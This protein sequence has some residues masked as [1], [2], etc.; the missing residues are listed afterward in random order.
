MRDSSARNLFLGTRNT[1]FG[2][3]RSTGCGPNHSGRYSAKT[4][5]CSCVR[6]HPR[7]ATRPLRTSRSALHHRPTL[8]R[9]TGRRHVDGTSVAPHPRRHIA[10]DAH[11]SSPCA[12]CLRRHAASRIAPT[13]ASHSLTHSLSIYLSL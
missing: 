5:A 3:P 7:A 2:P 4:G 8:L 10:R 9:P 13:A 11:A 12:R 1:H 6:D